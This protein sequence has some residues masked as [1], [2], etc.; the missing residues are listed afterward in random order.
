MAPNTRS[1]AEPPGEPSSRQRSPP[2]PHNPLADDEAKAHR[3]TTITANKVI[4]AYLEQGQQ[5]R[6]LQREL[7]QTKDAL[8]AAQIA[9]AQQASDQ[10][11]ATQLAAT[12]EHVSESIETN[13]DPTQGRHLSQPSVHHPDRQES[14]PRRGKTMFSMRE[15][16]PVL[17]AAQQEANAIRYLSFVEGM[18]KFGR[19]RAQFRFPALT[20]KANYRLWA[21]NVK[22]LLNQNLLVQVIEGQAGD[23]PIDHPQYYSLKLL[24][25]DAQLMI[26]NALSARLKENLGFSKDPEPERIWK[27]LRDQYE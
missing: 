6:K 20:G 22:H 25:G 27:S 12:I 4:L 8:A 24:K 18:A 11:A 15:Q 16:T 10:A 1:G 23:L 21:Q 7:S 13:P 14:T 9:A 5:M 26:A 3:Q 2:T 19:K 17:S